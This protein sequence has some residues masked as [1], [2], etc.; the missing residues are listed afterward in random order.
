MIN[1]KIPTALGVG[2]IL[3]LVLPLVF[4]IW[5]ENRQISKVTTIFINEKP[6]KDINSKYESLEVR[7]ENKDNMTQFVL[8]NKNERF[9]LNEGHIYPNS[10]DVA[11]FI[12]F[13]NP[14]FS[15]NGNYIIVDIDGYEGSISWVYDVKTKEKIT[16]GAVDKVGFTE[17][18]EY[19]YK[20]GQVFNEKWAVAQKV[21]NFENK[22]DFFGGITMPDETYERNDDLESENCFYDKEKDRIVFTFKNHKEENSKII[23][24]AFSLHN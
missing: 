22:F 18:E 7:I 12:I 20:C 8:Y 10:E 19:F 21:P 17:N 9:V 1:K 11:D 15:P 14:R 24:E 23:E 6:Q 2:I 5:Q 3:L 16:Y 4:W 13:K